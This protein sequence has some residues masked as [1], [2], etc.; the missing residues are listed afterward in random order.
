MP[1]FKTYL[2]LTQRM[3]M[4]KVS[5]KLM[6]KMAQAQGWGIDKRKL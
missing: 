5:I 4:R 1:G 3:K 6:K 2:L